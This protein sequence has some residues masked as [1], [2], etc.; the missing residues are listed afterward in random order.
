MPNPTLTTR[1]FIAGAI[2]PKCKAIDKIVLHKQGD[3]QQRECVACGFKDD[4]QDL[5]AAPELTTRVT[6]QKH[7]AD[8]AQRV[9]LIDPKK[10]QGKNKK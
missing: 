5:G 7:S 2:C 1:R 10:D 8:E 4:L 3:Q 9:T 6:P